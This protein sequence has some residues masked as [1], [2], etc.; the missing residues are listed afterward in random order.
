MKS[1]LFLVIAYVAIAAFTWS[2]LRDDMKESMNSADR[3]MAPV[4]GAIVWPF[5]WSTHITNGLVQAIRHPGITCMDAKGNAWAPDNG[6]CR[7]KND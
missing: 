3:D 7:I 5:Y 6:V 1:P 2:W 4:F